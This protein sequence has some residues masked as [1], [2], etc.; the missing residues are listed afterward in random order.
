MLKGMIRAEEIVRLREALGWD[1]AELARRAGM[2]QQALS[3]IETGKTKSSRFIGAIAEVL[4]VPVS[5]IDTSFNEI[6][7]SSRGNRGGEMLQSGTVE[8][9]FPYFAAA[10]GGDGAIILSWDAIEYSVAPPGLERVRD[11]Y[12]MYIVGESMEP[13]Y[14]RGEKVWVNPNIPPRPGNDVLIFQ[15]R[16]GETKAL[17]KRLVKIT[18]TEWHVSQFNPYRTFKLPKSSWGHCHVITGRANQGF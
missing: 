12:G 15:S 8:K 4:R 14:E 5:Q 17:V 18:S 3:L 2:K 6:N 9:Y 13:R 10:E 7:T 16:D 11:A 1:Q